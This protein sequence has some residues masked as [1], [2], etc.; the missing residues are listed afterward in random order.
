MPTDMSQCNGARPQCASCA[1]NGVACAYTLSLRVHKL[2]QHIGVLE[3]EQEANR[4]LIELLR[5]RNPSEATLILD[6]LRQNTSVQSIL[7]QVEVGDMLCN[8]LVLLSTAVLLRFEPTP[9]F[10]LDSIYS[11][12]MSYNAPRSTLALPEMHYRWKAFPH[13]HGENF[14]RTESV[15]GM[16]HDRG[17][18]IEAEIGPLDGGEDGITDTGD[19]EVTY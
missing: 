13:N 6:L 5:C 8:L 16:C 4:R 12:Q 7:R 19:P 15:T 2:R 3:T 14:T 18:V 11:D 17:I 1:K 9:H 10:I